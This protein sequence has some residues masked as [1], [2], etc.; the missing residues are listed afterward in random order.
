[1]YS[2]IQEERVVLRLSERESSS[3]HKLQL[4][5]RKSF[6]LLSKKDAI[7]VC[8]Y[9]YIYICMYKKAYV[10]IYIYLYTYTYIHIYLY[11]GIY[12]L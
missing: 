5:N 9:I 4:V 11:R 12:I 8:V 6:V 7:Y 2:M 1:M 3:E 10:Y